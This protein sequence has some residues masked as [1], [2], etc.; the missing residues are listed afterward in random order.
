MN[1]SIVASVLKIG[2]ILRIIERESI[3]SWADIMIGKGDSDDSFLE[4]S[5]IKRKTENEIIELLG[6]IARNEESTSKDMVLSIFM[7]YFHL[8]INNNPRQ[9]QTIVQKVILLKG[10]LNPKMHDDFFYRLDEDYHLRQDG[11]SG[12]MTMPEELIT[13][14]NKYEMYSNIVAE[15]NRYGIMFLIC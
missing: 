7:A 13:H 3:V 8:F 10:I 1:K 12:W 5:L 2:F 15:L 11:F 9:W 4:L 14:L 6:N